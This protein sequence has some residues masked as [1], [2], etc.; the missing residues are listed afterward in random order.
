MSPCQRHSQE[1]VLHA[2][3]PGKSRSTTIGAGTPRRRSWR[4]C[5]A[6]EIWHVS[7]PELL[8][9]PLA[10]LVYR[11][12]EVCFQ[13]CERCNAHERARVRAS[14]QARGEGEMRCR[15]FWS[16]DKLNEKNEEARINKRSRERKKAGRGGTYTICCSVTSLRFLL[17]WSTEPKT[18]PH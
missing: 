5:R 10:W 12:G 16:P 3:W 8:S 2:H 9:L 14:K 7:K 6:R 11:I 1:P 15:S 13:G 18:K 4:F 17:T